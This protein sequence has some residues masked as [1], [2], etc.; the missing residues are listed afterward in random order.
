MKHRQ[1]PQVARSIVEAQCHDIADG[2]Q[3]GATMMVDN[4]FRTARRSGCVGKTSW[5]PFVIDEDVRKWSCSIQKVAEPRPAAALR[6]TTF[7]PK[8]DDRQSAI[9]VC[10]R[11]DDQV[12]TTRVHE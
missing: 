9:R 8:F 10:G 5:L 7:G 6:F 12:A 1:C 2:I 3:V 11:A 4:A